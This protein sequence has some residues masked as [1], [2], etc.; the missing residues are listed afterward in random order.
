LLPA[1]NGSRMRARSGN[2]TCWSSCGLWRIGRSGSAAS[3]VDAPLRRCPRR[4]VRAI[5]AATGT[6]A[7]DG[8]LL[9]RE[10]PPWEISE[11]GTRVG[12]AMDLSCHAYL[13]GPAHRP[14]APPPPAR[15]GPPASRQER[16]PPGRH[17][18]ARQSPHA[19]ALVRDASAGGRP[20]HPDRAGAARP[21]GREHDH[22]LHPR[23]QPRTGGGPEPRGPSARPMTRFVAHIRKRTRIGCT[24]LQAIPIG[25]RP[26]GEGGEDGRC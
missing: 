8:I 24:D 5:F 13:S 9:V 21:P 12:L 2:R 23:P 1:R 6:K 3:S 22:D 10:S 26:R 11:C 20:R 18:E 4:A 14:D 25:R 15:V 7:D 16:R 17:R 19:P